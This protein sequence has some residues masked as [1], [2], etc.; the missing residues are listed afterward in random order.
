VNYTGR[1]ITGAAVIMIAVFGAFA[2]GRAS[3]MQ[4]MGFGL[5]IAVF[6]DV[7]LIR[8]ILLPA[9]LK[10]LGERAWWWPRALNWVPQI[11]VE[12]A[13]ADVPVQPAARPVSYQGGGE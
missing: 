6:L 3:E 13:P 8:S 12:G 9:G 2:M 4:Q 11:Q 5:A 7:T 10:L 1:I